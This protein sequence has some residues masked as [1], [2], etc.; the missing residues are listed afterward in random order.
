MRIWECFSGPKAMLRV[1]LCF[2]PKCQGAANSPLS[3]CQKPLLSRHS[4]SLHQAAIVNNVRVFPGVTW[5]QHWLHARERNCTELPLLLMC[6]VTPSPGEM[7]LRLPGHP[8]TLSSQLLPSPS[9]WQTLLLL[10]SLPCKH[11][12]GA[13]VDAKFWNLTPAVLYWDLYSTLTLNTTWIIHRARFSF[14]VKLLI[15]SKLQIHIR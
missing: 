15:S 10:K 1:R 14:L 6:K 5:L 12:F 13:M 4:Y 7:A 9:Y 8:L 11:T 3:V 2:F